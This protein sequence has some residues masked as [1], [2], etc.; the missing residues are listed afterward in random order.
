MRTAL[1]VID[2]ISAPVSTLPI[3]RSSHQHSFLTSSATPNSAASA[4]Y[5]TPQANRHAIHCTLLHNAS[6][7]AARHRCVVLLLSSAR[8]ARTHAGDG[9]KGQMSLRSAIDVRGAIPGINRSTGSTGG[10]GESH[11]SS[12]SP[13]KGNSGL[14]ARL[15]LFRDRPPGAVTDQDRNRPV[16]FVGIVSLASASAGTSASGTSIGTI[17]PFHIDKVRGV[18]SSTHP[19]GKLI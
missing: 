14:A 15:V 8:T 10:Y 12:I 1:L 19:S 3:N 9:G 2:T 5:W 11:G 13:F 17:V 4:Q 6:Q 7:F 16:W 18:S